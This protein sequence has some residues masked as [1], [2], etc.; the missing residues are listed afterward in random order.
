MK[1]LNVLII[2]TLL[3]IIQKLVFLEEQS[4]GHDYLV[5]NSLEDNPCNNGYDLV[6]Y[7]EVGYCIKPCYIGS[8]PINGNPFKCTRQPH[9]LHRDGGDEIGR[10][11]TK[12]GCEQSAR[13]FYSWFNGLCEI[14]GLLWYPQCPC[15]MHNFGCCVCHH[16]KGNICCGEG[17][18]SYGE[19]W[20][21]CRPPCYNIDTGG[22]CPYP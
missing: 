13:K 6:K 19:D 20:T 3:F 1:R 14:N 8:D 12:W 9:G 11:N 16:S 15:G 21:N 4:S 10:R 22:E 18:R 2:M 5:Y 7:N 17:Y